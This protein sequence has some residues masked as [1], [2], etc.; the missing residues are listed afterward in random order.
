MADSEVISSVELSECAG[1]PE[2]ELRELVEYGA[3]SPVSPDQFSVACL[4]RLRTAVRLRNDLELETTSF[5]LVVSFLERIESLE[6]Q[7][8][9]LS[10]QV[11]AP[12]RR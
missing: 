7:V 5:A 2:T 12:V 11:Q 10:A 9:Q 4:K 8:R 6:A 3:L 1:V